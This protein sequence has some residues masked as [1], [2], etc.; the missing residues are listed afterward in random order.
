M[1]IAENGPILVRADPLIKRALDI[2]FKENNK[3]Q[4]GKWHFIVG[5]DITSHSGDSKV[6]KRLKI[7]KLKLSFMDQ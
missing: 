2:Y 5:E 4:E 6:I 7:Q 3:Q 1:L